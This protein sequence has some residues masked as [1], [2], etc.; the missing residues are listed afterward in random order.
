MKTTA[1]IYSIG[2]IIVAVIFSYGTADAEHDSASE[3]RDLRG[4]DSIEARGG[5]DVHVSQGD[6]FLVEVFAPEGELDNIVTEIHGSTLQIRRSRGGGKFFGL[7]PVRGAIDVT[8]P[9]LTVVRAVGGSDI[10]SLARISGESLQI[11]AS[12]G[13]DITLEIEVTSVEVTS[14][15]GSDVTLTGSGEFAAIKTSG[16]SD[17]NAG[18]FSA[19]E[20]Q[21]QTSGGSEVRLTVTGR[22]FGN[23]S[24]GS[25]VFYLGSP[26]TVDVNVGGGGNL[27]GR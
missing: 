27:S 23:V 21:L 17:L 16:G 22:L 18:S 5:F 8:L 6:E 20:V 12:G 3:I 9:E 25:D 24:G 1:W 19:R 15:G 26:E 13:A 14:S 7:F 11:T 2:L 10:V 4:F